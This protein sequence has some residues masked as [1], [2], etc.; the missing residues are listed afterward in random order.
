VPAR[1]LHGTC[2]PPFGTI[3]VPWR[4][5]EPRP[6]RSGRTS[7]SWH[8]GRAAGRGGFLKPPARLGIVLSDTVALVVQNAQV[9]HGKRIA[10]LGRLLIPLAGQ[11]VI[12]S[13]ALKG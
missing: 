3:P 6:G 2:R 13:H 12:P 8:G 11:G 10:A 5:P 1:L 7:P 9:V 4:S